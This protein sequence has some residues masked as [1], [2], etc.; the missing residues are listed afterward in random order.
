MTG[1]RVTAKR[2]R[3]TQSASHMLILLLYGCHLATLR[4]SIKT[5]LP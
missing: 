4:M 2:D 5:K 1:Y 3:N